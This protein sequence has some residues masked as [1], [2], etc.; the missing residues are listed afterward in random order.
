MLQQKLADPF[1][2][3]IFAQKYTD[4]IRHLLPNVTLRQIE[5]LRTS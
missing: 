5:E 3:T 2:F 4:A 1:L